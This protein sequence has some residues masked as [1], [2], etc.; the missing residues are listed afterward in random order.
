MSY[1]NPAGQIYGKVL[2]YINN[3][4]NKA[5]KKNTSSS[6][7]LLRSNKP[8]NNTKVSEQ[9]LARIVQYVRTIQNER[10]KLN[11]S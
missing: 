3:D 1:T 9:P 2:E 8:M 5:I 7:G 11:G 10:D 6:K 4:K